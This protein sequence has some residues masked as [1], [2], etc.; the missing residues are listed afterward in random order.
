MEVKALGNAGCIVSAQCL[1]SL[2]TDLEVHSGL[3]QHWQGAEL[4]VL[5]EHGLN[6][7]DLFF[8]PDNPPTASGWLLTDQW[9]PDKGDPG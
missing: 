9:G 5:S 1:S 3:V 8:L 6:S 7:L 4:F 2:F